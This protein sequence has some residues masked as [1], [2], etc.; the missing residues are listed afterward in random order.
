MWTW[1]RARY[2]WRRMKRNTLLIVL[3]VVAGAFLVLNPLQFFNRGGPPRRPILEAARLSP[4]LSFAE[5][6]WRSPEEYVLDAFARHDVVMLGEFFK[7]RQNVQ[8]VQGLIPRL[9][10]AGIRN[11]G[12][13]YAL[14]DDQGQIDAL[15]TA[16]AGTKAGHAPSRSTGW[17]RGDTRSTSIS[18]TP[19]GR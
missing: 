7:I 4:L 8:L 19:P 18:T 6:S 3:I 15:L 13:E 5:S 11:L 17:S 14:S 1:G 2:Y 10:A 9:Y 16:P 12:I